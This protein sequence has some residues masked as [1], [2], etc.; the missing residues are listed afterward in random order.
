MMVVLVR[1]AMKLRRACGVY[2]SAGLVGAAG[3]L[4]GCAAPVDDGEDVGGSEQ[5]IENGEFRPSQLNGGT[6]RLQILNPAGTVWTYCSGQVISRDSIL[7][8]AHCFYDGGWYAAGWDDEI[9]VPLQVRHQDPDGTW[10]NLT[11][12]GATNQVNAAVF[13]QQPYVDYKLAGDDRARGYDLAVVR[14]PNLLTNVV[15]SDVSAIARPTSRQP[16]WLYA[17]GHGYHTDTSVDR[18]LRRGYLENLTWYTTNDWQYRTIV[19]DY[20]AADPH[21]CSGDSGGPWKMQA[22]DFSPISGIVFGVTVTGSGT[23]FCSENFARAAMVTYHDSWIEARVEPG[24][25]SCVNRDYPTYPH[26][27][28]WAI[29]Y[30]TS[31]VCW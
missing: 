29:E 13:I 8:A 26:V 31:L 9:S 24:R 28:D 5:P 20:D 1:G 22:I 19:T 6:V 14:S 3:L 30:V 21:I 27:N 17:Y 2:A 4:M 12:N 11:Q 23:G 25:G 7:T 16:Q 18:Q 10:E 15:S